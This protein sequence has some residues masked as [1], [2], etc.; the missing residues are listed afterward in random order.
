MVTANFSEET[1]TLKVLLKEKAVLKNAENKVKMILNQG[2]KNSQGG[3][4]GGE[5]S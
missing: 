4:V 1:Q 5:L 3:P 2:L